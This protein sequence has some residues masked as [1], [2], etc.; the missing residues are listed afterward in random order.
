MAWILKTNPENSELFGST[1]SP[2]VSLGSGGGDMATKSEVDLQA[3]M[4]H[5]TGGVDTSTSAMNTDTPLA[6]QVTDE[7]LD[8]L[9]DLEED[10]ENGHE[11][12]DDYLIAN[13]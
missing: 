12:A 9:D 11:K 7:E 13:V 8:L 10:D 6:N 2:V 3:R 4:T 1:R 5:L